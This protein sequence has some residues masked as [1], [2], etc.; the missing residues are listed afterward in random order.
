MK[1]DINNKLVTRKL[2]KVAFDVVKYLVESGSRISTAESLTGGL[3]SK[4]IT[5]VAGSSAVFELGICSYSNRI[6]MKILGVDPDVIDKYTEVSS[7]T[8]VQMCK[9]VLKL[10]DSDFAVSTT[11]IAGP[12]GGSAE[13]PVGTIYVCVMNKNGRYICRNLELNLNENCKSRE[14]FRIHTVLE[15]FL[16]LEE[17]IE[18][19]D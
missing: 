4:Y 8:A 11:G 3:V 16:M 13:K 19:G 7:Q 1:D 12:S 14:D 17:L 5:D 2:D 6:K 15:A 10:S 18:R 9:G